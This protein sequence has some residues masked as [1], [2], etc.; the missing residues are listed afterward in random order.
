MARLEISDGEVVYYE[1]EPPKTR[2]QTFVF[3]NALT[4]STAMWTAEIC[5]RLQAEG[6]GTLVWNFAARR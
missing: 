3:V 2:G 5:P 4:G 1:Y 6:Y